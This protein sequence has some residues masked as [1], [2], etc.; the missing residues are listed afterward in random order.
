MVSKGDKLLKRF[1]PVGQTRIVCW[2]GSVTAESNK[3][4]ANEALRTWISIGS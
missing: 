2:V 3:A 1:D 4:N